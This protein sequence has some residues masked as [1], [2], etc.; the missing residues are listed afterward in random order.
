VTSSISEHWSDSIVIR[1]ENRCCY[2]RVDI[3]SYELS[4]H[5]T[6][7][8][9][10][11]VGGFGRFAIEKGGA[12]YHSD[13]TAWRAADFGYENLVGGERVPSTVQVGVLLVAVSTTHA[14]SRLPAYCAA[15]QDT[16]CQ[17]ALSSQ[18][19]TFTYATECALYP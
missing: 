7:G 17:H 18:A 12:I 4:D 13:W 6:R 1:K 19:I 2:V 11:N 14:A 5:E 10:E 8:G 16:R 3:K 15:Q 9:D